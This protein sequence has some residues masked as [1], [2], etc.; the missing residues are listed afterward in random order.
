M[1]DE[2]VARSHV[3][4]LNAGLPTPDEDRLR[5]P[6]VRTF[7]EGGCNAFR[8]RGHE[9]KAPPLLATL[10]SGDVSARVGTD[11]GTGAR[12]FFFD[13]GLFQFP[14]DFASVAAWA[15]VPLDARK[16]GYDALLARLSHRYTM[17]RHASE[18]YIGSTEAYL[19]SGSPLARPVPHT[20][21][22]HNLYCYVTLTMQM[23]VFVNAQELAHL[24]LDHKQPLSRTARRRTRRST[25]PTPWLPSSRSASPRSSSA[26]KRWVTGAATWSSG[27]YTSC[28]GRWRARSMAPVATTLVSCV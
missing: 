23:L 4:H 21:P 19:V 22:P 15:V 16:L 27:A 6:V 20:P 2:E 7:F 18:L 5:Y 13:Q 1:T 11:P 14:F 3:G 12:V 17:P 10:P 26:A 25:K 9:L 28:T 8:D 24:L